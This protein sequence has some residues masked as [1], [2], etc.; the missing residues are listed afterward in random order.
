[1]RESSCDE[2][3]INFIGCWKLFL[4]ILKV[5]VCNKSLFLS[6]LD[7]ERT[8]QKSED[9]KN[10]LDCLLETEQTNYKLPS[11]VKNKSNSLPKSAFS[12]IQLRVQ[13]IKDQLEVLKQSSSSSGSKAFQQVLPRIRPPTSL[14]SGSEYLDEGFEDSKVTKFCT[15]VHPN[16]PIFSL[17][18]SD[19]VNIR[20]KSDSSTP[21]PGFLNNRRILCWCCVMRLNNDIVKYFLTQVTTASI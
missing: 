5:F 9:N 1:M 18:A 14:T 21:R 3:Q 8:H 16:N 13:E 15:P 19:S 10:S 17:A 12:N 7:L 20:S 4:R 6:L 2:C 11:A